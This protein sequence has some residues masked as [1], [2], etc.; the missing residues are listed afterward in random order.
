MKVLR[1]ILQID[2]EEDILVISKLALERY[3][4]YAVT[5][6]N[7]SAQALEVATRS[8][9]DLILLDLMMLGQD[10]RAL[11]RQFA[12]SAVLSEVPIVFVTATVAPELRQALKSAGAAGV[13][14]KPF[15]PK[16]LVAQVQAVW[17]QVAGTKSE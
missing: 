15:S 9:P 2:D 7:D 3:G 14:L 1:H 12:Q 13:I 17:D 8:E 6:C 5:T 16:E 11:A 10:G 4:G